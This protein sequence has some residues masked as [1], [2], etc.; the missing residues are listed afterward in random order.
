M[1]C[2]RPQLIRVEGRKKEIYINCG[3]C[4]ACRINRTREWT[5][6]LL[7]ESYISK[8]TYFIT[9]SY[10]EDNLP[11]D[12]N[13]NMCVCKEDVQKF[14]KRLRKHYPEENIRYFLG[15]E[16]GELGGRPHYHCIVYNLPDDIL[17]P[18]KDYVKGMPLTTIHK[19]HQSYINRK[20]NDIWQLG[21]VSIG[22]IN[23]QRV[24]YCAKYFITKQDVD[25]IL[26]KNFNLMSRRPGIGSQYCDNQKEF[27]RYK[28]LHSLRSDLGTFVKMPRYYNRRIYDE[29][30]R[31]EIWTASVCDINNK[32]LNDPLIKKSAFR[33]QTSKVPVYV[34]NDDIRNRD[35]IAK[36]NYSQQH[37]KDVQ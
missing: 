32:V 1:N 37:S 9:L 8:S 2:T 11:F 15:S 28:E 31:T 22:E 27:I 7:H 33:S 26:T 18:C 34:Y 10:N 5:Q 17:A 24:S 25:P 19:G 20:L 16:Y 4:L 35:E 29:E 36:H 12:N 23:R 30:E 21:F 14:F 6:R 3:Y 13:G